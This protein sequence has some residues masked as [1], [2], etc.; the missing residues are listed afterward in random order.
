MVGKWDAGVAT[1]DHTPLGRGY[2]TSL[3]YFDGFNDY[4]SE[5]WIGSCAG[6]TNSTLTDLWNGAGPAVGLNNSRACTAANHSSSSCVFEDDL[7]TQ[8]LLD[9]LDEH[10]PRVPLFFFYAPHSVHAPQEAPQAYFDRFSF[11][12]WPPRQRYSAQVNYIDTMIGA[13]V[14]KLKAKGMFNNTL[15]VVTADACTS[16]IAQNN[17]AHCAHRPPQTHPIITRDDVMRPFSLTPHRT[18]ARCRT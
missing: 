3:F 12:E 13:V 11:I 10:D 1:P 15:I 16:H 17:P 7:F 4:W 8:R 6:S 14:D 9:T 2:D 5:E 18:A